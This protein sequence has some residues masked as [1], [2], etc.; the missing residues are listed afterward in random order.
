MAQKGGVFPHRDV[1]PPQFK[2]SASGSTGSETK[3]RELTMEKKLG[4][5]PALFSSVQ[6]TKQAANNLCQYPMSLLRSRSIPLRNPTPLRNPIPTPGVQA[7]S[8]A[9]LM[10]KNGQW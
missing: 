3:N 4:A 5:I 8:A 6:Q 9:K 2:S 1:V 7:R 10:N